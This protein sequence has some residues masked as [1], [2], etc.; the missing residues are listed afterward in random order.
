MNDGESVCEAAY[1]VPI[2]K[3]PEHWQMTCH[4]GAEPAPSTGCHFSP[5]SGIVREKPAVGQRK[6]GQV[7]TL[8]TVHKFTCTTQVALE[9]PAPHSCGFV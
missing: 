5:H 7:T 9:P 6:H 2:R 1:N 8:F 3:E 4:V